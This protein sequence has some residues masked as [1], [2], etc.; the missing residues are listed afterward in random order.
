MDLDRD[1][2]VT[3]HVRAAGGKP[4]SK[5]MRLAG[6]G[7]CPDGCCFNTVTVGEGG[8]VSMTIPFHLAA[9]IA[10]LKPGE[11]LVVDAAAHDVI[12]REAE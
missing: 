5:E 3:L 1:S 12:S 11:K 9:T 10:A 7:R 4:T 8:I 2:S 6:V